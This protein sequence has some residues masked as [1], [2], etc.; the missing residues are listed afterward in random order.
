MG[1]TIRKGASR[2]FVITLDHCTQE[3][4]TFKDF[5]KVIVRL[6]QGAINVDKNLTVTKSNGREGMVYFSQEDTINF[7]NNSKARMQILL[8]EESMYHQLVVKTSVFDVYV[9]E[10]LWYNTVGGDHYEYEDLPPGSYEYTNAIGHDYYQD[11]HIDINEF[12]GIMGD[13]DGCIMQGTN[14]KFNP[15]TETLYSST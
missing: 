7:Q 12:A 5:E 9:E 15:S 13:V 8:L 3:S 6:S 10:S 4:Y 14:L 11:L 1:L 2:V